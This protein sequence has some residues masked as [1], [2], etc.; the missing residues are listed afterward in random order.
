MVLFLIGHTYR[1][2]V[3][4]LMLMLFPEERPTYPARPSGALRARV[5]LREGAQ[6]LTA[7]TAITAPDGRSFRGVSRVR[8]ADLGSGLQ[9][10]RLRQRAV[11]QSFYRAAVRFHGA[12][13]VWG[14]LSGIRPALL[15]RRLMDEGPDSD[16]HALRR[17]IALYDVSPERAALTLDAARAAREAQRTLAPEDVML[18]VGVPFCPTRCAYCSFVSQTEGSAGKLLAPYFDCLLREIETVGRGMK[19]AGLRPRTLYVGG[20]TPTTLSAA[21]LKTLMEAVNTHFDRSRLIEYTVEAGRP[22]T[23]DPEKLRVIRDLGAGRVSINPQTMNDA[24]LRAVGRPHTAADVERAYAQAAA[25][26]FRSVNMD[27]IAGLPGDD[28]ESFARSL[29]RV[30]AL[31]P[32]NVTVHTLALKKG[33][34]LFSRREGLPSQAEVETM[35]DRANAVL[36]GRGYTPYYLYRQKYMSGSLE[37]VGWCRDGD[38]CLYNIYMMEELSSILALGGGA[39]SK[40][41]LPENRLERQCNPKYP[42]QYVERIE[43]VLAAKKALLEQLTRDAKKGIIN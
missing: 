30:L 41:N 29:D 4:Q 1:D 24:V 28:P 25:A 9:A 31:D 2:A 26:G 35:V 18:Y 33:A 37:N 22:D 8:L 17:F 34:E 27:L 5:T 36:S 13:P 20:G 38:L 39:V 40:R 7:E 6:W 3:E 19:E 23:V 15:M 10:E 43:E 12:K 42:K 14:A 21:Q 32:S 11:K 16:A